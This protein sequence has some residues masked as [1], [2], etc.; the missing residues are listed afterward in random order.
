LLNIIKRQLLG[1]LSAITV[2]YSETHYMLGFSLMLTGV[3]IFAGSSQANL[4]A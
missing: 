2:K 3:I 4:K 1:F